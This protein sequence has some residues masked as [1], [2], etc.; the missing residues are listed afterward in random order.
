MAGYDSD[1]VFIG[2]GVSEGAKIV[3]LGVHKLDQGEKVRVVDSLAG[4]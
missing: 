2:S 3:T 1:S 4:L